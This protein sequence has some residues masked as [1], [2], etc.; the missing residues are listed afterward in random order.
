[1]TSGLSIASALYAGI[2]FAAGLVVTLHAGTAG[3]GGCAFSGLGIL[4]LLADGRNGTG[5]GIGVLLRRRLCFLR[6]RSVGVYD[7]R[8][9]R[10]TRVGIGRLL[11]L[12]CRCALH[13]CAGLLRTGVRVGCILLGSCRTC[14]LVLRVGL[15]CLLGRTLRSIGSCR[16][17]AASIWAGRACCCRSLGC[18][19]AACCR[20]IR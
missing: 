5:I 10:R 4:G 2:V 14:V 17:R 20:L 7:G 13:G 16:N 3:R 1:M 18:R 19:L 6:R 9:L 8:R 12:R 11:R 15:L